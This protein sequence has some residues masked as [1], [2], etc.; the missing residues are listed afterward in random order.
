MKFDDKDIIEIRGLNSN[1]V[2]DYE[3]G[4]LWFSSPLRMSKIIARYELYKRCINLPGCCAEF[5]VYKGNSLFQIATF[6]QILE[7]SEARTIYA[8]GCFGRFPNDGIKDTE[9]KKFITR[10]SCEGGDATNF[11]DMIKLINH[12]G[13]K[14]IF[15]IEGDVRETFSDFLSENQHIRFNFVHLDM[16]VYEPTLFV[17]DKIYDRLVKGGIIMIDD[18]NF[19]SGATRAVDKFLSSHQYLTIEKLSICHTPSFIIKPN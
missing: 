9:D 8:F 2:W 3:N 18:Y 16:D 4:W 5:G 14:N 19:V 7:F 13:F 15:L 11:S 10:F 12:K 6:R 17:L 1:K